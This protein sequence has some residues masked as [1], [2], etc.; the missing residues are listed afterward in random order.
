MG[1]ENEGGNGRGCV[2]WT[3]VMA[4]GVVAMILA[5]FGP[6]TWR[7]V[8]QSETEELKIVGI[9]LMV[10]LTLG[11]IILGIVGVVKAFS[12][13]AL[14]F[15]QQDDAD[16]HRKSQQLNAQLVRTAESALRGQAGAVDERAKAAQAFQ[17]MWGR[18]RSME[19]DGDGGYHEG[20]GQDVEL[21]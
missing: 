1:K 18:Q 17:Q 15:L 11:V 12:S 7:I 21:G 2:N 13:M 14:R 9:W 10:L 5:I 8:F 3:V 6:L 19:P 16:E 4:A 20:A